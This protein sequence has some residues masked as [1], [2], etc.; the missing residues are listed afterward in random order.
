[1]NGS[2]GGRALEYYFRGMRMLW[3]RRR[4]R[5]LRDMQPVQLPLLLSL[6]KEATATAKWF[7]ML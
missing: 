3:M 2:S 7:S 6:K 1:M 5:M 4:R